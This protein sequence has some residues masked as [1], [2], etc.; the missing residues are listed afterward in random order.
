MKF[1]S[2]AASQTWGGHRR[3]TARR[4]RARIEGQHN[5]PKH[6]TTTSRRCRVTFVASRSPP[7]AGVRP[8]RGQGRVGRGWPHL[9]LR[10]TSQAGS[11]VVHND[12]GSW[13]NGMKLSANMLP[14]Q[15]V[16]CLSAWSGSLQA[17]LG[18]RVTAWGS[19]HVDRAARRLPKA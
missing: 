16:A 10:A 4:C 2:R 18:Q 19:I 7:C 11:D 8:H 5:S 3:H 12:V 17:S 15:G 9:R 13:P 1:L 14:Y 6:N